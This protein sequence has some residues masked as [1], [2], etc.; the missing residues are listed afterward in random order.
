MLSRIRRTVEHMMWKYIRRR[1]ETS[2]SMF[3]ALP[4]TQYPNARISD[5]DSDPDPDPV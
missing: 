1:D 4:N 5:S 3:P 2:L